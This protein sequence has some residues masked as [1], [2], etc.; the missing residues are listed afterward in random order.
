M[1]L[2]DFRQGYVQKKAACITATDYCRDIPNRHWATCCP[3]FVVQVMS[4]A[5]GQDVRSSWPRCPRLM[6]KTSQAYGQDVR[7]S[8][9]GCCP[10]LTN[11]MSKAHGPTKPGLRLIPSPLYVTVGDIQCRLLH[12]RLISLP[13]LLQRHPARNSSPEHRSTFHRNVA[14]N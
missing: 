9:A 3:N 5:H 6:A 12:D 14:D 11:K 1:Y 10:K 2:A 7:S 4:K 8:R 13:E